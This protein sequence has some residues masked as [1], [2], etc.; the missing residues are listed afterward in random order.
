MFLVRN[1]GALPALYDA[2]I[3]HILAAILEAT[4]KKLH[5]ETTYLEVS[6]LLNNC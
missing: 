5:K 2:F 6:E 3:P 1:W 4:G